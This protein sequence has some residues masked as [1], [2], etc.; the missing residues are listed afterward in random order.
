[1]CLM[2]SPFLSFSKLLKTMQVFVMYPDLGYAAVSVT[3]GVDSKV[4]DVLAAAAGEWD[5]D[6]E[7][8]E[9]SFSGDTLCESERLADHGLHAGSELEMWRKRFRLFGKCWFVN[10]S[11]REKL[12][13][14]LKNHKKESLYLDTSTFSEDGC[15]S[16]ESDLLP[17]EAKQISFCNSNSDI[18]QVTAVGNEFLYSC[19]QI[20]ALDLSGLSSVTT[21]GNHFLSRCAEITVLDL[22]GLSSVT[23]IGNHFLSRCAEITVLD[24]S[25]LSS[26]TTIGNDFMY[27]CSQITSLDLSSLTGVTAIGYN[28]LS[29]SPITVLDVSGF[30]SVTTIGYGFLSCCSEITSLNLS[31]LCS[32]TEVES[33]F[34]YYCVA[35]ESVQLP[36]NNRGLFEEHVELRLIIEV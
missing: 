14:W 28:F 33:G 11:K 12:L 13:H 36:Q 6:L 9:L 24:L 17:S 23:T 30:S 16:V 21:I 5:I 19:S 32:V 20:S 10:D 25:G 27:S 1:M 29:C 3:V 8:V 4:S 31:S 35:L 26:V 15:L 34:L 18:S 7:E 2:P 22:S